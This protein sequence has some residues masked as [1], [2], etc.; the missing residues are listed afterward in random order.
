MEPSNRFWP[1]HVVF[2][3]A[4]PLSSCARE[5]RRSRTGGARGRRP[6]LHSAHL[7]WRV[8]RERH[9]HL[10]AGRRHHF[11]TDRL[12][13]RSRDLPVQEVRVDQIAEFDQDCWFHGRAPTCRQVADHARRIRAADLRFPV[14][15]AAEAP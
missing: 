5:E 2:Q 10:V 1:T 11:W 3:N 13:A 7:V 8:D 4:A 9:S 12:W 15:P 6:P 14:V